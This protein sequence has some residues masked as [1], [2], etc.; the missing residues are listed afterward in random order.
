MESFDRTL[1][2]A[3]YLEEV[4]EQEDDPFTEFNQR[5]YEALPGSNNL[6]TC[7]PICFVL[8]TV[9]LGVIFSLIILPSPA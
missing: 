3:A 7:I 2:K 8:V 1:A 4:E 6:S 9:V 5:N